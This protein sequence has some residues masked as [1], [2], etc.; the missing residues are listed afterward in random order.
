MLQQ[1]A[2]AFDSEKK[3]A[4]DEYDVRFARVDMIL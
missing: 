2:A 3:Q 4:D 1:T